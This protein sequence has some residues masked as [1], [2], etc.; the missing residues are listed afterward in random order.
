ML[1]G[2]MVVVALLAM[3]STTPPGPGPERTGARPEDVGLVVAGGAPASWDPARIGDADSAAAL[4]QVWEGLTTLDASG[5]VQPALA[6]EWR[7]HPDGRSIVFTLRDDLAFSDGRPIRAQDVVDSWLRVLDPTTRGPLAWLLSDVRGATEYLAGRV[8]RSGVGI[9]AAGDEV[10]VEFRRPA[11]YFPS[12]AASPTL[13][14][15][16]PDLGDRAASARLPDEELVVSGAYVPVRQGDGAIL[17][18]ANPRYWDGPPPIGSVSLLTDT[19]GRSPVEVFQSGDADH[20]AIGSQDATWIAW[21]RELGPALRRTDGLSVEYYGFDT[22]RP[23][24][25]DVRVR[26][27]VAWAVDWDRLVLL[28]DDDATP[29]TSLVPRGIPLRGDG[30]FTPR[31]DPDAAR[32]ELAAAG[33]P[34]GEGLGPITLVSSGSA[35][36]EAVART[37][38]E[39]LGM[40][41]RVEVLPFDAYSDRLAGDPPAMWSIDWVADYPHPQDFLGLLLESGSSSNVGGWSHPAF[42]AALA[43]AASTTDPA[44]V[45]AAY[46]AAQRIVRDEVPVIPLRYGTSWALSRDGLLGARDPGIGF[47]R[48]ASLAWGPRR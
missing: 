47:L 41:V 7:I 40:D 1:A 10:V 4:A 13:A 46:E 17:L 30:D 45:E 48:F 31:Y 34:G 28:V 12:V 5:T 24:F 32:A 39:E 21:D 14:V 22:T 37:L 33:Y 25:D 29:A 20:T 43:E 27:A 38:H 11:S 36:D 16:P 8:P 35:Y 3:L 6:R 26:R 42:D 15:V 44:E 23:P 2:A 18:E 9:R 19:G